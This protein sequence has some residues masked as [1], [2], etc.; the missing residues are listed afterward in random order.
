MMIV[1]FIHDTHAIFRRKMLRLLSSGIYG[2]KMDDSVRV[3]AKLSVCK[4]TGSSH[5]TWHFI[6]H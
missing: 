3:T 4:R 2:I 6:L 5:V 1:L